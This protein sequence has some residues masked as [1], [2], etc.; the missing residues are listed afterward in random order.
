MWVFDIDSLLFLAA[1]QAAEEFYGYSREEFL[2]MTILDIRPTQDIPHLLR[3][4][5]G[6]NKHELERARWT[7]RKKNGD[8]IRVEITSHKTTFN[9]RSAEIV[10]VSIP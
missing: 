7:H 5:F 8:L 9:A 3:E 6:D 2:S 1:N 4:H 10:T